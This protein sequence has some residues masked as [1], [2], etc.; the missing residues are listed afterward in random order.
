MRETFFLGSDVRE[1]FVGSASAAF[2]A[3]E[4]VFWVSWYYHWEAKRAR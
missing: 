1:S 2:G 3:T 4:R